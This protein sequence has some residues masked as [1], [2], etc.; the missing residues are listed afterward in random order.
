MADYSEVIRLDPKHIAGTMAG[1]SLRGAKLPTRRSPTSTLRSQVYLNDLVA[2]T[3]RARSWA[4]KNQTDKA[5]ADYTAAIRLSPS[6]AG[7]HYS[8]AELQL[9]KKEYDKA[10]ADYTEAIRWTRL[11]PSI[12]LCGQKRGMR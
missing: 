5:I 6:N 11:V 12:T 1:T 9:I 10:I 7:N 2:L 4:G 8:R 3:S